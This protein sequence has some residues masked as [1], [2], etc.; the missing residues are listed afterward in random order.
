MAINVYWRWGSTMRK[1]Q[2]GDVIRLHSR[3]AAEYADFLEAVAD[4]STPA[5]PVTPLPTEEASAAS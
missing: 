5:T 3:A 4:E 2:P 1:L